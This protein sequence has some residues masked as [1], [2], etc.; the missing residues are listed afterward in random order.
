MRRT[1]SLTS[2]RSTRP[3]RF[4]V[5]GACVSS[6]GKSAPSFTP[7]QCCPRTG[8]M[9]SRIAPHF[10][11]LR[12]RFER[13]AHIHEA[14]LKLPRLLE[15]FQAYGVVFL[16]RILM[17]W[18]AGRFGGSKRNP[19]TIVCE[20]PLVRAA[21]RRQSSVALPWSESASILSKALVIEIRQRTRAFNSD[22]MQQFRLQ[23]E[24]PQ[25]RRR[26]LCG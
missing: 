17:L 8:R 15:H 16:K 22:R 21:P 1:R 9:H 5:D 25:D 4:E 11:R 24:Q 19:T 26:N 6:T 10:R 3:K 20:C 23:I 13:R 18:G 2:A 7:A 12:I 14:F